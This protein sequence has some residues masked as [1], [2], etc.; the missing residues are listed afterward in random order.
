LFVIADNAKYYRSNLVKEY[1]ELNPR[2]IILFLPPYPP[3]LN[4]IERLWKLY[5]KE[6][7]YNTYYATFEEFRKSTAVFFETISDR[8]DELATLW[9]DKF[10]FPH[11]RF[12]D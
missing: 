10:Y 4:L 1:L 12:L 3:N 2:I 5:K 11:L 8:K 6:I 9:R 7:L